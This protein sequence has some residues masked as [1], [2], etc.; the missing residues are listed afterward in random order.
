MLLYVT[1]WTLLHGVSH[2]RL[3]LHC[4]HPILPGARIPLP[5]P[6]A[7]HFF[8]PASRYYCYWALRQTF[9]VHTDVRDAS[10]TKGPDNG[11]I[12]WRLDACQS[13]HSDLGI[14]V[15][16]QTRA[17]A[18]SGLL[19]IQLRRCCPFLAGIE[20]SLSGPHEST[21]SYIMR[22]RMGLKSRRGY[23]WLRPT[24][25][26]PMTIAVVLGCRC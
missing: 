7:L 11:P 18:K 22:L 8:I 10:V 20:T 16:L 25:N 6:Y 14:I 9:H 2:A 5:L 13:V 15:L 19:Q 4:C 23:V 1:G 26:L 21:M 17:R 3:L 24:G 12:R